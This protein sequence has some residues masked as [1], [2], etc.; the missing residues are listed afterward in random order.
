MFH[1]K[2]LDWNI[3]FPVLVN[4]LRNDFFLYFSFIFVHIYMYFLLNC[5]YNL[6]L[7]AGIAPLLTLHP[8]M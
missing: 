3:S 2:P 8:F 4:F 7:Q 1:F 6:W 5:Y